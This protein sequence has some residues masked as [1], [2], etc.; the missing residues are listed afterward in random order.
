M[1]NEKTHDSRVQDPY[2]SYNFKLLIGGNVEAHFLECS[3]MGIKVNTIEYRE[4]GL[5][6]VVRKIPGPVEYGDVT[7]KYG[8]TSSDRL[9]NW[10]MKGVEGEVERKNVTIQL[11]DNAGTTVVMNWNLIDAW[12][13]EWR[14]AHLDA[15]GKEIAVESLTLVFETLE[16]GKA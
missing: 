13:S 9:W 2:R 14:G 10:F 5:K 12:P 1:A 15:M 4:S 11:L 3:G 16:K 7:L 8:L 6:Q